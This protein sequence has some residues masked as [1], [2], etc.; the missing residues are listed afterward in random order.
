MVLSW[1]KS[2]YFPHVSG[3]RVLTSSQPKLLFLRSS[4]SR[5]SMAKRMRVDGSDEFGFLNPKR[6]SYEFAGWR[7]CPALPITG[8]WFREGADQ[9]ILSI[10]GQPNYNDNWH[11]NLV[12]GPVKFNQSRPHG[13]G[14]IYENNMNKLIALL[15]FHHQGSEEHVRQHR[16]V[17]KYPGIFVN[18]DTNAQNVTYVCPSRFHLP[19]TY[20]DRRSR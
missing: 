7:D 1:R 2:P 8:Y 17:E 19:S 11:S 15:E 12:S 18:A 13:S 14:T 5:E 6:T 10:C 9:A 4:P 16:L 3:G 20:D